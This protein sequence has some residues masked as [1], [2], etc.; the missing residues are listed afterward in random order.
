MWAGVEVPVPPAQLAVE[1]VAG[2]VPAGV[3][4]R[5]R[6]PL[7]LAT[8]VQDVLQD[9]L[10]PGS[11]RPL[12]EPTQPWPEAPTVGR[13][14]RFP[15]PAGEVREHLLEVRGPV[16]DLEPR[17]PK[18][19]EDDHPG[20]QGLPGRW[21]PLPALGADGPGGVFRVDITG[22]VLENRGRGLQV[23]GPGGFGRLG[24]QAATKAQNGTPICLVMSAW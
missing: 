11:G 15:Y 23:I 2:A 13:V 9:D 21:R 1:P 24:P 12:P 5:E 20:E 22:R 19:Q 8:Q 4:G 7:A 18:A 10:A 17:V 14:V 3:T 6:E 16:P